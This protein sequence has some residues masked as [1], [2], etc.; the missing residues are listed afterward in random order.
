MSEPLPEIVV[1]D[2]TSRFNVPAGNGFVKWFSA[3]RASIA[4]GLL[5]ARNQAILG[6]N[7]YTSEQSA[8]DR[9]YTDTALNTAI[10]VTGLAMDTDGTPYFSP[11]S[12]GPRLYADTDGIPYFEEL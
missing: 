6:A 9:A 8:A 11:G 1:P 10:K 4:V 2:G 7:A 5:E 12:L 3:L